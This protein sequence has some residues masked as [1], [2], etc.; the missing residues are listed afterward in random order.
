[1]FS[2]TFKSTNLLPLDNDPSTIPRHMNKFKDLL[3]TPSFQSQNLDEIIITTMKCLHQLSQG[4]KKS[5]YG[6]HSRMALIG[7]YKLQAQCLVQFASGL[8]LRL[9]PD[10]YRQLSSMSGLLCRFSPFLSLVLLF[11]VSVSVLFLS[12]S[13]VGC[14]ENFRL[15]GT[16]VW[17]N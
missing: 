17:A 7:S 11:S 3:D 4:L 14:G 2:Q 1:M 9:G 8:R 6:D 10:V 5:P 16:N 15:L 13:S 12:C